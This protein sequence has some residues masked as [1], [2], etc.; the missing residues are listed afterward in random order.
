MIDKRLSFTLPPPR[1]PTLI[2]RSL[3]LDGRKPRER[4]SWTPVVR[5]RI[6]NC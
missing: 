3:S 6:P 4:C 5:S 1:K 2:S